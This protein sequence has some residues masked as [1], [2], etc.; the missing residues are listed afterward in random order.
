MEEEQQKEE[1]D[2]ELEQQR[3]QAIF[4]GERG[5]DVECREGKSRGW[6]LGEH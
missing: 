6:W 5:L 2:W 1:E 3:I 4:V